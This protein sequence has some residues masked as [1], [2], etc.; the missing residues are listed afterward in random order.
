MCLSLSCLFL[1]P[2]PDN[3]PTH[4]TKRSVRPAAAAASSAGIVTTNGVFGNQHRPATFSTVEA[5]SANGLCQV[6]DRDG[7][8][9]ELSATQTSLCARDGTAAQ[10]A[11]EPTL[12]PLFGA[13]SHSIVPGGFEV[14]S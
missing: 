11:A 1:V 13:H 4:D 5:Q 10:I 7:A 6:R 12:L 9:T 14:T 2:P 8:M 3:Q